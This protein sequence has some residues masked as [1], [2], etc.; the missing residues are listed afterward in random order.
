MVRSVIDLNMAVNFQAISTFVNEHNFGMYFGMIQ[1][2]LAGM[3][4]FLF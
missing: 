1:A 4:Y 3:D 2:A